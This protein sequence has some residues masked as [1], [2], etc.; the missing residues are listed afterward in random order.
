MSSN[1]TVF[2]DFGAGFDKEEDRITMLEAIWTALP[3]FQSVTLNTEDRKRGTITGEAP[4]GITMD[5]LITANN[6]RFVIETLEYINGDYGMCLE[7]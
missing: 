3:G 5:D 6:D 7:E 2:V 4:D 1:T